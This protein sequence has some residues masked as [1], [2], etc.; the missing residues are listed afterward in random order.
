MY[1]A[2]CYH[3]IGESDIYNAVNYI[4]IPAV[5]KLEYGLSHVGVKPITEHTECT[6]IYQ[7]IKTKLQSETDHPGIELGYSNDLLLM[8]YIAGTE[9]DADIIIFQQ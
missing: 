4:G 1:A 5:L 2:K 8:E 7:N 6:N 3:I 9:H